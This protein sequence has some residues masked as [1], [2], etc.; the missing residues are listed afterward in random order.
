MYLIIRFQLNLCFHAVIFSMGRGH[1]GVWEN[2]KGEHVKGW[3]SVHPDAELWSWGY[4]AGW[5]K[6][7]DGSLGCGLYMGFMVVWVSAGGWALLPGRWGDREGWWKFGLCEAVVSSDIQME[8]MGME[9]DRE[10]ATASACYTQLLS[11]SDFLYTVAIILTTGRT[12]IKQK[13][14]NVKRGS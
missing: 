7:G 9:M 14:R 5:G 4:W 11:P 12:F 10:G 13:N 8:G 3:E 1:C 6:R 2:V